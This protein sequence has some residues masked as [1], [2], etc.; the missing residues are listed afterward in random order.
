M[1]EL[2]IPVANDP[3]TRVVFEQ[4][5]LQIVKAILERST[6][7]WEFMWRGVKISAPVLDAQFYEQFFAHDITIAPGDELNFRL[8]RAICG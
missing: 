8:L 4:C 1:R 3:E 5:D 6:R 2:E 7:K